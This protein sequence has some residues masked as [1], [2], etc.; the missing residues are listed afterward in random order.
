LPLII[1]GAAVVVLLVALVVFLA[2]RGGD[3]DE[4]AVEGSSSTTTD[5]DEAT[6]Q[7]EPT[8]TPDEST[9]TPG[10]PPPAPGDRITSGGLSYPALGGEWQPIDSALAP[11]PDSAGQTQITQA[12]VPPDGGDWVASVVIGPLP[13]EIPY[14][15]PGDLST[16]AQVVAQA[17]ASSTAYPEGTTSQTSL[18]EP[19]EID[20]HQ[21][22]VVRLD[23]SY[24]VDG[25]NATGETMQVA[26][27]DT[28]AAQP[29]VFWGSIPN[30]APQLV[31]DMDAAFASLTVDR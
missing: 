26:V 23:L 13:E 14:T 5:R 4:I 15:G 2:A 16:D 1:G 6:T 17:L 3:D 22:F 11:F 7:P 21:A 29:G 27:I 9:T 18:S 12:N 10:Q 20:G 30:D 19:R 8:T 25:L 31:Q 24:Q 28:G